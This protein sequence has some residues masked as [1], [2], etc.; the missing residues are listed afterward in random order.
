MVGGYKEDLKN[1]KTVKIGGWAL[2]R[3]GQ[4]NGYEHLPGT[5]Q[6][7]MSCKITQHCVSLQDIL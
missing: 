6:Y 4:K 5:I 2:P 3:V 1:H 7:K